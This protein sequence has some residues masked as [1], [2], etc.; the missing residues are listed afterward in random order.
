M[1]K[2]SECW[3]LPS[4]EGS[5]ETPDDTNSSAAQSH[6]EE[7]CHAARYVHRHKVLL[8]EF[9][10]ALEQVIQNLKEAQKAWWVYL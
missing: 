5:E 6:Q 4:D 8:S 9:T 3:F 1:D 2:T 7:G 10:E